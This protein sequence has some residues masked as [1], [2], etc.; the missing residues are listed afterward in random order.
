MTIKPFVCELNPCNHARISSRNQLLLASS[1]VSDSVSPKL[2]GLANSLKPR[3]LFVEDEPAVSLLLHDL[4]RPK[5]NVE[6]ATCGDRAMESVRVWSPEVVLSDMHLSRTGRDSV[7]LTRRIRADEKTGRGLTVLLTGCKKQETLLR[8]LAPSADDFLLKPV[9]PPEM[10][11]R[12]RSHQ[13][14]IK[15]RRLIA[16]NE[17]AARSS[18]VVGL[19]SWGSQDEYRGS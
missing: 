1:A 8:C 9:R 17:F 2:E 6:T 3:R 18:E 10:L 11:A 14:L 13:R 19:S 4:L 5:Y 12:L 15:W 7:E 16:L